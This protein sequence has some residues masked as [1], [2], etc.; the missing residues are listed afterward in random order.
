MR[1]LRLVFLVEPETRT[2]ILPGALQRF[3]LIAPFAFLAFYFVFGKLA[4]WFFG[5]A[6]GAY[7]LTVDVYFGAMPGG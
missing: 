1:I 5:Y 7:F 3:G 2:M 4:T 6:A